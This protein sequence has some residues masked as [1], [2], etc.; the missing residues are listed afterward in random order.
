MR[1]WI[2]CHGSYEK[3]QEGSSRSNPRTVV[4]CCVDDAAFRVELGMCIC[5]Q[6]AQPT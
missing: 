6:P 3:L 2:F 5:I 1:L 4:N